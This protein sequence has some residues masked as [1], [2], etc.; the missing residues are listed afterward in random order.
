MVE[1]GGSA[2]LRVVDDADATSAV[3]AVEGGHFVVSADALDFE[4]SHE[5]LEHAFRVKEVLT[6]SQHQDGL[7]I[8]R[9]RVQTNTALR[10]PLVY[11]N[12]GL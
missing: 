8:R 3:G 9:E 4:A 7:I 1:V 12:M 5:Q 2:G 10:V 6:R 11:V